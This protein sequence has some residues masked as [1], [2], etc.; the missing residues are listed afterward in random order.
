MIDYNFAKKGVDVSDQ[1]SSYNSA[2]RKT[3]K[4]YGQVAIELITGTTVVNAWVMYNKFIA[5]KK[6]F[7]TFQESFINYLV[8]ELQNQNTQTVQ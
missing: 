1:M 5:N 4:W 8:I 6:I 2:L 3:W 7:F